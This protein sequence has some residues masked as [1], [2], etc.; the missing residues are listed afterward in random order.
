M[1]S[2]SA[3][4]YVK[5]ELPTNATA[6]AGG[7]RAARRDNVRRPAASMSRA[8]SGRSTRFSVLPRVRGGSPAVA[9]RLGRI[10]RLHICET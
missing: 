9:Q 7:G 1:S 3:A 2:A 8:K 5:V 6:R 10:A 4:Q